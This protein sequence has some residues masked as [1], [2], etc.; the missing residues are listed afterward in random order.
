[1]TCPKCQKA[2]KFV[3]YRPKTLVS[4]LGDVRPRRAYYHCPHCRNGVVPWD[5]TPGLSADILT[6]AASEVVAL[7]GLLSSFAEAGETTLPKVAGLRVSESTVE[8]VTEAA[9]RDIGG[10]L[11]REETFGEATP[12]A[13]HKDAEGKTCAYVSLD[14][15]GVGQQGERGAKAEGRMVT[16]AMVYN[17]VPETPTRRAKPEAKA[18]RFDVRYL[19]GLDGIAT[20]GEPLRR[21][22]AQVGM[23]RADRWIALS[24]GGAGLEDWLRVNFGRVDAIILDFYHATEYLGDLGRALHP[25]DEVT[26]KV[27]L[28]AWCHRLKHEGGPAVLEGLRELEVIGRAASATLGEVTRYF[29]NQSHRMDYPKYVSKGWAIGSGPIESA[30]KTVVGQRMKGAGMRWGEDGADSVA[31]LRALFKSRRPAMGRL[32]AALDDLIGFTYESDAYPSEYCLRPVTF[33]E[34]PVRSSEWLRAW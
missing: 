4:L 17:P 16:V 25:D 20:L 8:R 3:G 10:R 12:W 32:L 18:P 19:A 29:T 11:A 1:M 21:Q 7:T 14:A 24:D 34:C 13:W 27:W 23:D 5:Q 2:A 6:P 33:E 15:T 28:D 30:C 9:G 26:R 22:A 31:H